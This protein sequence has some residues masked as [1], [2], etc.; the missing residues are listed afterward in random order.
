MNFS[1]QHS[2]NFKSKI[3]NIVTNP[4]CFDSF[5]KAKFFLDTTKESF[6]VDYSVIK[7]FDKDINKVARGYKAP[8]GWLTYF[9]NDYEIAI[10][11]DLEGIEYEH[12]ETG[13]YLIL[14]REIP[15]SAEKQEANKQKLLSLMGEIERRVPEYSK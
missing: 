10:P 9:S 15:I 7:I 4:I 12:T 5:E 2:D 1:F 6:L 14:T 11:D 3:G 8:L 13:K